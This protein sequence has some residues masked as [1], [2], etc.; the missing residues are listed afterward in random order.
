MSNWQVCILL[1]FVTAYLFNLRG[2]M[3]PSYEVGV[4]L[5]NMKLGWYDRLWTGD[6]KLWSYTN[7]R[8]YKIIDRIFISFFLQG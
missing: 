6:I 3:D 4:W 1:V 2:I 5:R 8:K 7:E